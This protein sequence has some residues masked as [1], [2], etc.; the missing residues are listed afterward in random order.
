[1]LVLLPTIA[2]LLVRVYRGGDWLE[3]AGWATVRGAGHDHLV[4]ALVPDL[5]PAAGGARA[6]GP[7]SASRRWP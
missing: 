4:P 7:I 6:S 1:M 2:L 5:V 3:N